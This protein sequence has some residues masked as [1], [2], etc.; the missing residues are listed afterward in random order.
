MISRGA[1][2]FPLSFPPAPRQVRLKP[3]A[4]LSVWVL[5]LV[6]LPFVLTGLFAI[7]TVLKTP[8]TLAFGTGTVGRVEQA[9][10]HRGRHPDPQRF[11]LEF[12]Y[13]LP[14][15]I[16]QTGRGQIDTGGA[17]PPTPGQTLPIRVLPIGG[18]DLAEL[19]DGNP[20]ASGWV[21]AGLFVFVWCGFVALFALGAWLVPVRAR[22]L[23]R[24][25]TATIGVVIGTRRR[26]AGRTNRCE[27]LYRFTTIE[28]E[29]RSAV[30]FAA[31]KACDAFWEGQSVTVIYDAA[32]PARSS[33]YEASDY[34]VIRSRDRWRSPNE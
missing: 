34:E 25:G 20:G 15:K 19:R 30:Q 11:D 13:Q 33:I 29:A 23:A 24:D 27:I 7:F 2:D 5:R 16:Q 26:R 22:A 3:R 31:T 21:C 1:S 28:G 32:R 10:P 14:G 12:T 17:K 9:K 8:I 6:T 4:L 18:V